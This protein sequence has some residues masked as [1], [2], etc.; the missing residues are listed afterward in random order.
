MPTIL[1]PVEHKTQPEDSADC[2][3]I[4]VAMILDYLDRSMR[5]RAIK[6]TLGTTA[7]GTPASNIEN[8]NSSKLNVSYKQGTIDD[9]HQNIRSSNPCIIFVRTDEFSYWPVATNHAIVAVGIDEQFIYAND[10]YFDE[11]PVPIPIDEFML[12]WI[13]REQYMG[14]IHKQ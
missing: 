1:L 4:C 11:A 10:P 12:G 7:I 5:L 8:L 9:I 2:L 14:L 6:R 13:E 3:P